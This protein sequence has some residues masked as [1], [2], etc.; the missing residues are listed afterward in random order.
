M[1]PPLTTGD[2]RLNVFGSA[3]RPS[4]R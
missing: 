4:V 1:S 3:V 2:E